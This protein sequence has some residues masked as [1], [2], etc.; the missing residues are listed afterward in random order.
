MN[1]DETYIK[2]TSLEGL[3][4][5]ERPIFK[6]DRGFF[7]ETFRLNDLE[8]ETGEDFK[9]VQANHS[10]SLPGVIR[11]LHAENWNKPAESLPC[12]DSRIDPV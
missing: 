8:K 4:I 6:D 12:V 3:I 10:Y 7:S 5:I 11:A 1:K 2:K 9:V